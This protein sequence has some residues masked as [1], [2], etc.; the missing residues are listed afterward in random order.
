MDLKPTHTLADL[1]QTDT[2]MD[3]VMFERS[4]TRHEC[5]VHLLSAP[6]LLL[7]ESGRAAF[8]AFGQALTMA[9]ALFPYV[10]LDLEDCVHEEQAQALIQADVIL[11]ILRL[12]FTSLRNAREIL[13]HLEQLGIHPGRVRLVAN[14]YGQ[15]KEVPYAK[16]EEA[17][18]VK[19]YHYVPDE[20]RTINWCNNNG[21]PAV[22]GSPRS[23]VSKSLLRLASGINGLHRA[24]S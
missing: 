15:P 19:I 7:G 23:A 20:P 11:V 10:V 16:A 17:L 2:R 8:Q 1:G 14:R 4:L 21:I 5:G 3:R 12:D 6:P 24:A 9:R 13:G 22:L 18:G